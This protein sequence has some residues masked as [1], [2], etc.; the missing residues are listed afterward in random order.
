[1]TLR[2]TKAELEFLLADKDNK[3]IA[4]TGKW[5][6]GKSYMWSEVKKSSKD[7]SIKDSLYVSLFGL[8]SLS[9]AK[10]RIVQSALARDEDG[11]RTLWKSITGHVQRAKKVLVSLDTRF[12]ALDELALLTV[13]AILKGK[14]IVIDDIE[15]MHRDLHIDELMGFIDEFVQQHDSRF[16]LILNSDQLSDVQLWNT[17]HE[18]VVDQEISLLTS[19]TEAFEIAISEVPSDHNRAIGSA[20]Q[21]CGVTNIRIIRKIIKVVNKLVA[22]RSGLPEPVVARIV[23][24][25]VLLTSIHYKGI[26]DGPDFDFVLT[27]GSF[28]ADDIGGAN[29]PV[30]LEVKKRRDRWSRLLSSLRIMGADE[31]ELLIAEYLQS[32]LLDGSTVGQLIDRYAREHESMAAKDQCGIFFQQAF[33]DHRCTDADLLAEANRLSRNCHLL[34]AFTV[35]SLAATVARISGGEALADEILDRWIASFNERDHSG[36]TFENHFARP[37]H[38]RIQAEFEAATQRADAQTTVFD[39]C[40][41]LVNTNGWGD[42]QKV[43]MRGATVQDMERLIRELPADQLR[44][45]IAKMM[46]L[47]ANMEMYRPHFGSA[48]DNFLE[49]CRVIVRDP[50]AGRLP[51]LLRDV[52]SGTT[53]ADQLENQVVV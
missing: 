18:K 40:M 36:F 33:W 47:S 8:G 9:E 19:A 51:T 6:T 24:S 38:A 37:I 10:I 21:L 34:D 4:L 29:H 20:V 3:V 42:R 43:A 12:S 35:T 1:M 25:T 48:M 26:S 15:R 50:Q 41:H 22:G 17:L 13:P 5:G 28:D 31:F 23:P 30:E 46:D 16:L 7:D 11:G 49:A 45:F 52:F 39:A 2:S 44:S 53:L 32:G 27:Y 14:M